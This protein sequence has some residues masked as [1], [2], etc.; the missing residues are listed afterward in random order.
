MTGSIT[1]TT[2]EDFPARLHRGKSLSGSAA[3]TRTAATCI[4]LT[5]ATTL[6]PAKPP[7]ACRLNF[8][9]TPRWRAPGAARCPAPAPALTGTCPG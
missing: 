7:R 6:R 8:V 3:M 1:I 4:R 2:A 9:R 5:P